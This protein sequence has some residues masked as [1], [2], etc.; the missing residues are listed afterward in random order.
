MF[1]LRSLAVTSTLVLALATD[2]LAVN[3][4]QKK[5]VI[6]NTGQHAPPV[7]GFGIPP[8]TWGWFGAHY[9]PRYGWHTGYY[10][11]CKEWGYRQGY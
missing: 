3:H 5:S 10:G 9:W 6:N 1:C 7:W 4:W 8:E 11:D 2:A